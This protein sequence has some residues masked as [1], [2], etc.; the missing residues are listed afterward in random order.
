MKIVVFT[1]ITVTIYFSSIVFST[2]A[3]T[4]SEDK[5]LK[6]SRIVLNSCFEGSVS[7]IFNLG[8][9]FYLMLCGKQYTKSYLFLL[10]N[11]N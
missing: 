6:M 1:S 10:W 5:L 9:T 4:T 11:Q 2:K 7:Q 8:P 3:I